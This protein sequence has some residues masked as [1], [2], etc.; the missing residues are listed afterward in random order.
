MRTDTRLLTQS[1]KMYAENVSG[2]TAPEVYT[3]TIK[4]EDGTRFDAAGKGTTGIAISGL[5]TGATALLSNS[6]LLG[7]ILGNGCGCNNMTVPQ[8]RGAVGHDHYVTQKEMGYAQA[9]NALDAKYQNLVSERYTDSAVIAQSEKDAANQKEFY[10]AF[11]DTGI[12][13]TKLDEQFKCLNEKLELKDQILDLRICKVKDELAAAIALESE[14]RTAGDQ[15]LFCYVNATFVPGKLVMP[16]DNIC[17][18]VM[19]E[20]NSWTAPTTPTTTG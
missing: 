18:A 6:G 17:P 4:S 1:N 12:G 19:P 20:Y 16:K 10:K 2:T 3:M 8:T 9:L 5:V 11:I 13:I 15:N 14:R 7:N